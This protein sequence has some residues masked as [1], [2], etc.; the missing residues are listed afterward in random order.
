MNKDNF[1][2]DAP[3][4]PGDFIT[5][6]GGHPYPP[7]C[8]KWAILYAN[9]ANFRFRELLNEHGDWMSVNGENCFG[10]VRGEKF[11]GEFERY[12]EK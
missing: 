12:L 7:D 9:M 8:E 10:I 11:E 2:W 1:S 3:F 6:Y 5:Q 4:R